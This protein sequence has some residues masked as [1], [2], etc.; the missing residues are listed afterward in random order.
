MSVRATR[1]S[2]TEAP[3]LGTVRF[4]PPTDRLWSA[5][6]GI[7]A[8]P[9]ARAPQAF[10]DVCTSSC[11]APSGAAGFC[12]ADRP[13]ASEASEPAIRATRAFCRPTA[14]LR[15]KRPSQPS[16]A[17]RGARPHAAFPS[18]ELEHPL[19]GR[20][21]DRPSVCE[22]GG[23]AGVPYPQSATKVTATPLC[24]SLFGYSVTCV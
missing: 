16:V 14:Q 3:L 8:S 15:L 1:R 10:G 23:G 13:A 7:D 11:Q 12:A 20:A 5:E 9:A 18:T 6:R 2:R 21:R 17:S 4:R 22:K 19:R 24:L